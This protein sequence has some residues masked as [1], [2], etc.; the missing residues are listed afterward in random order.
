MSTPLII[1]A[2]KLVD[3]AMTMEPKPED[4]EML[5]IIREDLQRFLRK[6]GIFIGTIKEAT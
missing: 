6:R 5:K 2:L 4:R 3:E 1:E